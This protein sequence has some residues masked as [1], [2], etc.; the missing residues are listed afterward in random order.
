MSAL[1]RLYAVAR[2]AV[3]YFKGKRKRPHA[4]FPVFIVG[5]LVRFPHVSFV[6]IKNFKAPEGCF[7]GTG[8]IDRYAKIGMS[9]VC[10]FFRSA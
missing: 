8:F 4:Y 6:C 10:F 1:G 9:A 3:P 7:I 2:T 5:T